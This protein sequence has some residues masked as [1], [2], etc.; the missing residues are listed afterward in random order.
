MKQAP[1]PPFFITFLIS[2]CPA[3]TAYQVNSIG[4]LWR[5]LLLANHLKQSPKFIAPNSYYGMLWEHPIIVIFNNRIQNGCR[6]AKK[7][8][9]FLYNLG[10]K[11]TTQKITGTILIKSDT[12]C[13]I[14]TITS[15]PQ[16][17]DPEPLKE[18]RHLEKFSLNVSSSVLMLIFTIDRLHKWRLN[19]NITILGT[20]LASHSCE[21]SFVLKQECEAKD[22]P[23]IVIQI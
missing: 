23:S 2:P 10:R 9:S 19:L 16:S 12:I 4:N 3:T 1:W 8:N 20:S 14:T 6:I 15:T 17:K 21:N 11:K 22:V 18:L 13:L 5:V 7:V